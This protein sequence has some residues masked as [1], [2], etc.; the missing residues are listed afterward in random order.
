MKWKGLTGSFP[1]CGKLVYFPWEAAGFCWLSFFFLIFFFEKGSTTVNHMSGP[2]GQVSTVL[3][4][5]STH[6]LLMRGW[7]LVP[8]LWLVS[9]LASL[10][11]T[12]VGYKQASC[13]SLLTVLWR[14]FFCYD[15]D[16]L[17]QRAGISLRG[18]INNRP[19]KTKFS[20]SQTFGSCLD[21]SLDVYSSSK[22]NLGECSPRLRSSLFTKCTS[23]TCWSSRQNSALFDGCR[24]VKATSSKN[25]YVWL[26]FNF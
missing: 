6:P 12:C 1:F 13:V 21:F 2:V 15:N 18:N 9:R 5:Q 7:S 16:A 26:S 17:C 19:W 8:S 10:R 11:Y 25:T 3:L 14:I 20:L 4:T 22:F 23:V 24:A